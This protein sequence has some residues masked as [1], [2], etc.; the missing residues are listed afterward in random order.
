VDQR[1]DVVLFEAAAADQLTEDEFCV[2]C[3]AEFD[4]RFVFDGCNGCEN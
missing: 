4:G 3:V 2:T 1:L